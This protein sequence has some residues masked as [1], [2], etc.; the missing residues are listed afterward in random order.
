MLAATR[1]NRTT[2]GRTV[3]TVRHNDADDW[4][5]DGPK[6]NSPD[7]LQAIRGVIEKSGPLIVEHRIYR[8]GR[9]PD[10]YIFEAYDDFL[11]WLDGT[12]AGDGVIVWDYDALCLDDNSVTYGKCP[13]EDGH[14]PKGGAY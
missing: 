6:I 14:V 1:A 3:R 8:G 9:A 5:Q 13:D 4:S 10:R 2:K 7:R 11:K 12:A